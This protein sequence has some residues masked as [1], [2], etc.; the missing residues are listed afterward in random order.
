MLALISFRVTPKWGAPS[1]TVLLDA[2]FI[3][4]LIRRLKISKNSDSRSLMG[5]KLMVKFY[6]FDEQSL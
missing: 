6:Y 3:S 5:R 4:G 1:G 2:L